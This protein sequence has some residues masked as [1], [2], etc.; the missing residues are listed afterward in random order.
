MG[1]LNKE[2]ANE[3]KDL[4][5]FNPMKTPC[6]AISATDCNA[7]PLLFQDL[8]SRPVVADFTGGTSSSDGGVLL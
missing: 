2:V 1:R 6:T 5:S 7:Q 8:G 3:S 4:K